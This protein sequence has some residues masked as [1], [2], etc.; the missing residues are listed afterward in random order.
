MGFVKCVHH[1]SH[2]NALSELSMPLTWVDGANFI[3]NFICCVVRRSGGG[4]QH[5]FF[6]CKFKR[7]KGGHFNAISLSEQIA[8]IVDS[9]SSSPFLLG[10]SRASETRARV[11]ITPTRE[12]QDAVGGLFL[13]GVIFT[14]ARVSLALLSLRTNGG[15]LVVYPDDGIS[16]FKDATQL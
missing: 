6:V 7:F 5:F 13:R 11:K 2:L 10:D 1:I 15:L 9:T 8:L 12:K 14:R 4:T 16:I 3:R